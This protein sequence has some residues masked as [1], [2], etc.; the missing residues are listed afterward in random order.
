VSRFPLIAR[1]GVLLLLAAILAA[2]VVLN[3]SGLQTSLPFW[4]LSLLILVIF[5][6]PDREIPSQPMAVVSPADGRVTAVT[7]T[8]DPYLDRDSIRVTLQMNPFGVFTTRSPV[9]GKVLQ[10][11]HTPEDT[12]MPHGVWLQTD[13][14]DDV[15]MVMMRGRLHTAPRCYIRI[16]ERIGQGKRCG[17]VHLGGQ[18]DVYLPQRSRLAVDVGDWVRSGSDVIAT[19][20]HI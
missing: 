6:D 1:E 16:G 19:L 15:V 17:F 13:E 8:R 4:G 7:A 18:V 11:P 9:E 10:P 3:L 12:R 5:R 20:V 14:G 2:V